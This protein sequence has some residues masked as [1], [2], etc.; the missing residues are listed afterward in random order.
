MHIRVSE[1]VGES[2]SGWKGAVQAAVDEASRTIS[3]IVGVEVVN[4]TANVEN[5]RVVEYKA[6]VK[7]A[8]KG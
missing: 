2:T 4:L 5:G 6:N 7:I 3:D 1:M 8:H